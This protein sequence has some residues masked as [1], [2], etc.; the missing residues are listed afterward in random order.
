MEP[1]KTRE[2]YNGRLVFGGGREVYF[3]KHYDDDGGAF[4]QIR[5]GYPGC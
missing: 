4:V 2:D 5:G 3:S 1:G